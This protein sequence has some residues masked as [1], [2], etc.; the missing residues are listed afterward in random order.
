MLPA[1]DLSSTRPVSSS[2]L[3]RGTATVSDPRQ[4]GAVRLDQI[5][6]GKALLAQVMSVNADGTAMVRLSSAQQSAQFSAELR[7]QLP[8]GSQAGDRLDL[9][10]LS[11]SPQLTFGVSNALPADTTPTTLSQAARLI[12]TL[13]QQ[14][15]AS[16]PNLQVQ[17][18]KPLLS[19]SGLQHPEMATQLATQLNQAVTQSG[20]FYEAHLRQWSDGERTLAQIRS[21]PQNQTAVH[22]PHDA[23]NTT[24]LNTP[25]LLPLQLDALE[26]QRLAWRGEVWPGQSMQWD[27]AQ[28]DAS[29]QAGKSTADTPPAWQTVL[30]LDL[31]RLGK[32]HAVIRM[33]GEQAQ[34]QMRVQDEQ[35]ASALKAQTAVLSEA[36]AASGTALSGMTVQRDEL[37]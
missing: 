25:P 4:D 12:D 29:Q 10:L 31:P 18:A 8:A 1:A 21:E 26:Q 17:G 23:A 6:I 19:Q 28:E 32:V 33:E 20:V 2:A 13:L 7:M 5:S 24:L 37:A 36:M 14:A 3:L 9:T 11:K 34:L 30:Q 27:V 22:A 35:A 15:L 16:Q